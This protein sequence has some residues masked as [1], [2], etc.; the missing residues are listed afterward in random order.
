[1]GENTVI[2]G[3]DLTTLFVTTTQGH[4][5]RAETGRVGWSMYP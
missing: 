1:V 2:I 3:P 5:F 4:F